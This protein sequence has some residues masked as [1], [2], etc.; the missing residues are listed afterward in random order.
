MTPRTLFDKL[1]D[2]HV[3]TTREDGE[4]LLWVD[5]HFLHEGSH[6]AFRQLDAKQRRVAEPSLTFGVADHYVPTRGVQP[7][8]TRKSPA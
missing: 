6:H 3:V 2:S 5:R 1:W 8:P 4:A 7:S